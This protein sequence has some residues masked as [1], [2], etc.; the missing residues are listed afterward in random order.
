MA[1]VESGGGPLELAERLMANVESDVT[2]GSGEYFID[3]F[4]WTPPRHFSLILDTGSDPNWIQCLPCHDCFEQ[5]VLQARLTDR[6]EAT[7]KQSKRA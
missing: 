3:V 4:V 6:R 1:N 2:L 7:K 5:H